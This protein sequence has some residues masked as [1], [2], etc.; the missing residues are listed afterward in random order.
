MKATKLLLLMLLAGCASA[1][2]ADPL[3]SWND[4]A[5]KSAV[6]EYVRRVTTAARPIGA[7]RAAHH[8]EFVPS[9]RTVGS[10]PGR[11]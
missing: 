8:R 2:P 5:T 4:G 11:V 6:L 9:L 3:P 10:T 1:R 7:L